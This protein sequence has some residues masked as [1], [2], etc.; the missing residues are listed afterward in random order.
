MTSGQAYN[1]GMRRR[2]VILGS[3]SLLLVA[4]PLSALRAKNVPAPPPKVAATPTKPIFPEPTLDRIFSSD[5]KL[6]TGVKPEDLRVVMVTGDVIPAR[7]ANL[8][9][10]I[11]KDFTWPWQETVSLLKE[12]DL[13]IINLEAPLMKSCQPVGTGFTFCGDTRHL[14]GF[15]FA[16]IDMVGL[17]NNHISNYSFAGIDETANLLE[18]AGIAWA[19]RD[20]L[21]IKEVRG[22]K[23]GLLAFNGIGERINRDQMIAEI[24]R[25]RPQVDVLMAM[26]HWGKE[27]ER[28]PQTDGSIAP[29]NPREIAHL[30]VDNGVDLVIGNH[31]H[32]FQA[33]EIYQGHV[34]PYAHGNFIFDQMWSD[35]TRLGMVGKYTFYTPSGGDTTDHHSRLVDVQY[36]PIK[37]YDYAQPRLLDVASASGQL[38][39]MYQAS[40]DL[41]K[42]DSR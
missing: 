7:G 37:I 25:A 10:I 18:S 3:L 30:A 42:L 6:P 14:G 12:G 31:P 33:V 13:R 16:G 35:E 34:I 1:I 4:V 28:L 27:Y 26:F 20:H 39:I 22:I 40:Q 21:G 8:E 32:W 24:K 29:D 41:A 9:T 19:R 5:H 36:T 15:K 23:F 17:E 2:W 38:G 11:K